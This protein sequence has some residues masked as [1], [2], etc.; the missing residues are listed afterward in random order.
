MGLC[1]TIARKQRRLLALSF[2][3]GM[4]HRASQLFLSVTQKADFVLPCDPSVHFYSTGGHFEWYNIQLGKVGDPSLR[5]PALTHS[6][7]FTSLSLINLFCS[8]ETKTSFAL[9]VPGILTLAYHVGFGLDSILSQLPQKKC[10]SPTS[11]TWSKSTPL[12]ETR[13]EESQSLA[14]RVETHF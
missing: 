9:S 3:S 5:T 12:K 13:L 14:D 10:C 8:G 1:Q 7:L 2:H 11:Q 4:T 6:K